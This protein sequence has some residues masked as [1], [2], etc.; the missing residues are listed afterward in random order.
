MEN[1][2]ALGERYF[3]GCDLNATI[4]L[5]RVAVDDLATKFQ[6]NFDSQRALTRSSWS[7]DGDYAG[8]M[9][10]LSPVFRLSCRV[11]FVRAHA[12]ENTMR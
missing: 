8:S 11:A 3:G 5:D 10:N 1:T 2:L 6:R 4:D 12:R 7:N 9:D